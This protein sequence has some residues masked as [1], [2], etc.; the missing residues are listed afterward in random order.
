MPESI[1]FIHLKTKITDFLGIKN[2]KLLLK[3]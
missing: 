1:K 2:T 3:I